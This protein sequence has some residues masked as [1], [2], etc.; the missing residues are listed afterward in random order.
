VK[1]KGMEAKAM[2]IVKKLKLI[3]TKKAR[4]QSN[5]A[6]INPSLTDIFSDAIGLSLVLET[7]LSN[8]LS[9]TSLT[10]HPADLIKTEPRKKSNR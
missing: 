7:F 10:I 8:F 4:M 1:A 2:R 9:N 3:K 5:P 6:Y